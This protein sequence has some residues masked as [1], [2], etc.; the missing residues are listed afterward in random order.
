MPSIFDL[1]SRAPAAL[2]RRVHPSHRALKSYA[3][4]RRFLS[5]RPYKLSMYRYAIQRYQDAGFAFP[6]F[7][8]FPPTSPAIYL[9]HDIDLENCPTMLPYML[10]IEREHGLNSGTFFQANP[11]TPY[12]LKTYRALVSDMVKEGFEVGLHSVCYIADDPM[13]ELENE[14]R[15]F[16]D[17]LGL[18]PKAINAHG[19]GLYK[20]EQRHAFYKAVTADLLEV[21]GITYSEL[22]SKRPYNYVAEDCHRLPEAP[23]TNRFLR[24]DFIMPPPRKNGFSY[25]IL[26]HPGY[27]QK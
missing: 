11:Q 14:C 9:R 17:A 20:L 18:K 26:T 3:R 4:K 8:A 7:G 12:H 25:L 24:D 21:L 2:T 10:E 13:R 27:W 19:L 16:E 5:A 6:K 15:R 1:F 22:P 23:T